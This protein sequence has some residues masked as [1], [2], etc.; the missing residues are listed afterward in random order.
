MEWEVVFYGKREG[1]KSLGRVKQGGEQIT[2]WFNFFQKI[3]RTRKRKR[4]SKIKL[5]LFLFLCPELF[6]HAREIHVP[7]WNYMCR[8]LHAIKKHGNF[9]SIGFMENLLPLPAVHSFFF[10]NVFLGVIIY[11]QKKKTPKKK[12]KRCMYKKWSIWNMIIGTRSP[13]SQ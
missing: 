10:L 2:D 6:L 1:K 11:G 12:K 7:V 8:I 4:F 5:F 13:K 3:S 9:F